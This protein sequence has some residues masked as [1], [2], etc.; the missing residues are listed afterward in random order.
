MATS[1]IHAARHLVATTFIVSTLLR[2]IG[3]GVFVWGVLTKGMLEWSSSARVAGI[4]RCCRRGHGSRRECP[5][6][7]QFP[8]APSPPA[9]LRLR[10][11]TR[12]CI[13]WGWGAGWGPFRML[14]HL[15]RIGQCSYP[16]SGLPACGVD[17]AWDQA[18]SSPP[19]IG[20]TLT[21]SL[22]RI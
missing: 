5:P 12:L 16:L 19:A 4:L 8:P 3:V 2:V 22:T 15:G 6:L 7:Q 21:H 17:S 1:V 10:L 14:P 20:W 9:G 11:S 18:S 13:R